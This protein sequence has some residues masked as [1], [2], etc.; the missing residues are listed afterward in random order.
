L[1][2]AREGRDCR[3]TREDEPSRARAIFDASVVTDLDQVPAEFLERV[4]L[5]LEQHIDTALDW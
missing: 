4:R 1:I 2:D 3:R 5:R